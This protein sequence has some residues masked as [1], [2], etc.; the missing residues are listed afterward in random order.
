MLTKLKV[1]LGVQGT[2]VWD[3]SPL[4]LPTSMIFIWVCLAVCLFE[5]GS[6]CVASTGLE[7]TVFLP[8]VL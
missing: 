1:K 7:V 8:Q 6:W 5:E 2:P 3:S 4:G